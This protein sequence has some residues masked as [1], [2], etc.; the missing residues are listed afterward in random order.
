[1]RELWRIRLGLLLLLFVPAGL[2][3]APSASPQAVI[4]MYHRF[5]EDRFPSTSIKLAQFQAQ[6]DLLDRQGFKVLPLAEV[7]AAVRQGR[8][9]PDKAVAITVDDAY[10]SVYQ[11]AYPMLRERGWPFTVFVATDPV[12][13][14]FKSSMSWA[15]MREMRAHGVSFAN[16]SRR[17][18]H[19]IAIEADDE[20]KRRELIRA[21]LLHA[22]RRLREELGEV[23]PFFA[24]PYGEYDPLVAEVVAELGWVGFGQ[25]S[26]AFGG[27]T[28]LRAVPRFP[29]SDWYGEL[30]SFATKAASLAMPVLA[31]EPFNPVLA[32]PRPPRLEI[33]LAKPLARLGELRC[34]ASQQ[35][36]ITLQWLQKGDRPRFVVQALK[37]FKTRRG[38]YNCTAPSRF[39]GR[40]YWFSHQWIQPWL[41]EG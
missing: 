22:Q 29:V 40:Y 1:M 34:Y 19:L 36:E 14:G 5:G 24:Y 6:L 10:L 28:D 7:V 20:A 39:K 32:E 8:A 35:G 9:L 17:H 37:A 33:T 3:A 23:L 41:A 38:R 4:F 12:D 30:N 26:G 25:H 18:G 31:A 2:L 11:H 21:E 27:H 13:R 16:H 15:Q